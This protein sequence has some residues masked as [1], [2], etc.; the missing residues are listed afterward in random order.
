[1][2]AEDAGPEVLVA[3]EHGVWLA[4]SPSKQSDGGAAVVVVVDEDAAPPL[5]LEISAVVD[6]MVCVMDDAFVV[7]WRV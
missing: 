4:M 1:M 7:D 3:L 6:L 5:V 2:T